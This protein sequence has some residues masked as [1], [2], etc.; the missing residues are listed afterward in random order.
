MSDGEVLPP[1]VVFSRGCKTRASLPVG[2][3]S[4]QTR[5]RP[6]GMLYLQY[7]EETKQ[8]RMPAEISSQDTLWALFVTAFPH[9]LTMKMLQ[10]PS[11][12]IYIKDTSRNVYYD[13]DNIRNITPHCCLKVYHKDPAQVFSRHASPASTEGR[14]CQV[15]LLQGS[16]L[17]TSQRVL[18][19]DEDQEDQISKEVL[20]GSHS[21]VHTLSSSSRSTLHSL[22]GSMSPPIIRS[23]PS[24]PSRMAYGGG[25]SRGG[26][27]VVGPGN[28]TLSREG[29][30]GLGRSSSVCTSSSVILERRDV[31]PED[32]VGKNMALV[33]QGEG[34]T[35]YPDSY[36]S[37]LQ[38]G[39]EG[40][41]S[42]ASSQCSA[43]PSL[44]ADMVDAGV[45][46]I[47]G[48]LHQYQASIKPLMGYVESMEHP[49]HSL[50]RQNSRKYGDSQLSPL[51]TKTPPS[52]PHRLSEIR[53]I[54]GQVTGGVGL[55]SPER[56]S[57]IRRSLRRKSNGAT[58]EIVNRSRG[59]GSSSS[60]S[61]VFVDSPLGQPERLFQGHV[62]STN[63]QSERMK[64]MEEQIASLAGL[65]H[66]ALSMGPGVPGVKDTVSENA[67]RKLHNRPVSSEPQNLATLI[68][69]FSPAP[70]ALQAPLS[71]G[72][73]QQRLVLAKR[74]VCELRLQLSQ[75]RHLQL[76]NQESMSL[77]LR[78][79]GQE[80]VGLICDRLA[81]AKEA[82][83]R[84]RAEMEEERIQYL[85]T[86]DRILSQLNELEDYVDRL[87][88]SSAS[89]A[90]QLSITLK[91]VEEGAVSLRRV[92]EALAILKGEFPEL[93]VKMRSVL[94]LEVE[95]VHFLK[96]EPH[97]MDSMLKRVRSLTVALSSLHR[98]VSEST[99][100]DRSVQGEP[101]KVLETNQGPMKTQ[102]P[103]NSPTPQPRSSV[104][105][106]IQPPPLCG[107]GVSLGGSASPI[108]TRRITST[109]ATVSQP[110]H[111]HLS[112]PLI[113]THGRDSPT[114]AKVSPCS[115][116]GSSALHRRLGPLQS[117]GPW[118]EAGGT[119]TQ[120]RHTE[121]TSITHAETHSE[122][123]DSLSGE[124]S[125]ID[126][127]STGNAKQP[128]STNT[129]LDQV[130]QEA[131]ASLK[132][133]P[134][135]DLSDTRVG[136][137]ESASGQNLPLDL[138]LQVE[139]L[140]HEDSSQF[141]PTDTAPAAAELPPSTPPSVAPSAPP[142]TPLSVAP[143]AP[144]SASP[145][146]A[147]SAAS[148]TE[149]SS[150]RPQV[151]K[152]RRASVDK[153]MKQGGDGASRSPPPPPPPRK[154]YTLRSGVTT[155][156]SGE[157][158]FTTTRESAG[159]Q[160]G[161]PVVP[162]PKPPR[163]PPEVKLKPQICSPADRPTAGQDVTTELSNKN[164]LPGG[165]KQWK[166]QARTSPAS[167]E[168][169]QK[170]PKLPPCDHQSA[171]QPRTTDGYSLKLVSAVGLEALG[172]GANDSVGPDQRTDTG[173]EVVKHVSS[174]NCA[175]VEKVTLPPPAALQGVQKNEEVPTPTQQKAEKTETFN[176]EL[177]VKVGSTTT[178]ESKV[179][180]TTIVTLQKGKIQGPD[181]AAPQQTH[182]KV[183]KEVPTDKKSNLMLIVT[184]QKENSPED[185]LFQQ[186][187][188][189]SSDQECLPSTPVLKP[190]PLS[191]S[192]PLSH[193]SKQQDQEKTDQ[194]SRYT[195]GGS[196]SPDRW[197][198]EGPPPP[199]PPNSR[200]R[201]S[202]TRVRGQSKEENLDQMNGSD[203][204]TVA[205]DSNREP[206]YLVHEDSD[207]K[208]PIIVILDEPMYI[209]SAYK[210]LST[211]FE[212][213]EDLDGILSP[214][215]IVD[216]EMKQEGDKQDV[217]QLC[218]T[219]IN[220]GLGLKDIT[221]DGQNYLYMHRQQRPSADTNSGPEIQD[222]GKADSP[223]ETETKWKFKFRFPKNKLAAISQ[224]IRTGTKTR[225]KTVVAYEE[226]E[227][228]ASDRR[229][230]KETKTQTKESKSFETSRTKHF[231]LGEGNSCD[232][233]LKVS[234]S[235]LCTS[236]SQVEELCKSTL[237]SVGS[238][239]ESIK[240][241]EISVGSRSAPSSPSSSQS[242]P[243]QSPDS[244]R[245]QHRVKVKQERD[246]SLSKRP[247]SQILKGPNPPQ[248]KRAR[249]QPPQDSG[250]TPKQQTSS[251]ISSS[252]ALQSHTKSRHSSSSPEKTT[253]KQASQPRVIIPR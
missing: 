199:P 36:C 125:S 57:P 16:D 50:H 212:C 14:L 157:V 180:V 27:G 22:Q 7:G 170:P 105:P 156:G 143:S 48:G 214:E 225:K 86:E 207:D 74:S 60:T 89:H 99:P 173:E 168:A 116:E 76:S 49:T 25:N 61:S 208:R 221:G 217:R 81:Q 185:S 83:Y 84:W 11:M 12:A 203:T 166:A 114:V 59:S 216:E 248:S 37:S 113:P 141:I 243:P 53:M 162:Q 236:H 223:K 230:G 112:P 213:E 137:S 198:N 240:Q 149:C 200:F 111:H 40:R 34:G 228:I 186:D 104:R 158:V 182:G 151:E 175:T 68:D 35:H 226:E 179:K 189:L 121:Q 193:S 177:V 95:A 130:L 139:R 109:A 163:Q 85:A 88:R 19:E 64:A 188:S 3:L 161:P 159:A 219:E 235:S 24:S 51:G 32:D 77:M 18:L 169:N 247:A 172:G 67:G 79:A 154:F 26:A 209:Q 20:Y 2:R 118:S 98:Y 132:S 70:L 191:P 234:S 38:D 195:E 108:M 229:P 201:I 138:S 90:G 5:E 184:L 128:P 123:S 183:V 73:L 29:L 6:L 187:K 103:K 174:I 107:T 17:K 227:E 205:G 140:T 66:H 131:Q 56:M 45:A 164:Y 224:A 165:N 65:V 171:P 91:D 23:M 100:Q 142:S 44:S 94:R 1:T 237:D 78:M 218:I 145:L 120:E 146:A 153:E 176:R 124:T 58:V 13:L 147:P 150:S 96:E 232:R 233:D 178:A 92:G 160:D 4:G 55:V 63:T 135:L 251:I 241:L 72:G 129:D 69:T 220:T 181:L 71:D 115:R 97:K 43:P 54:D 106:P 46:G 39:G 87:Q 245:A 190:P 47:P 239:E 204:L 62:T 41:L 122:T 134:N 215:S 196:L 238:L 202:K 253:Q 102:S 242:A 249:P 155:G 31:K 93:Q 10:S 15:V 119:P 101:L 211:I 244:D 127:S 8:V 210:R 52:S 42:F 246:K 136:H 167:P 148:S 192:L 126:Q 117:D 250:K 206:T 222:Q 110:P 152:P 82:A 21:P 30:S 231:N 80:L 75:L 33:V 252:S 144:Q 28:T 197:D 9:Q 194:V 133:I